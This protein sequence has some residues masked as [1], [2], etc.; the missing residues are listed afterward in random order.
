MV[1]EDQNEVSEYPK[2]YTLHSQKG[3]VGKTSIALAVAGLENILRNKKVVVIDADMT[4]ASLI[5]IFPENENKNIKYFNDLLLA[6]PHE[7]ADYTQIYSNPDQTILKEDKNVL[8]PFLQQEQIDNLSVDYIPA[9]P[10]LKDILKVVPLISQE[11][12]LHFFR[13]RLE[14]I[15]ATLWKYF[16]VIIIDNPPGLYG[17]SKASLDMVIDEAIRRNPTRLDRIC[18]GHNSNFDNKAINMKSIFISTPD[19][20]DYKALLPSFSWF[21]LKNKCVKTKE[22]PNTLEKIFVVFNKARSHKTGARFDSL[23]VL[24]DIFN[25][26]KA[27]PDK[28]ELNK[29]I[30]KSLYERSKSTGALASE[31]VS[32]FRMEE[33]LKTIPRLKASNN[34]RKGIE[35]WCEQI[36]KS[37]GIIK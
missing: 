5:D 15:I 19:I 28:R 35:K 23:L 21:L 1:Q 22:I 18:F 14:D 17:I 36:G 37:L 25:K 8:Q 27:F 7:F 30:S 6:E 11:D 32:D 34:I 20:Q 4:G 26:S 2:L 16:E 24:Q 3:G 29:D 10:I 31:Y 33:I 13:H 12:H 9:S